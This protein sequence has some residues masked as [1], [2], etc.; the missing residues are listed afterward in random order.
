MKIYESPTLNIIDFHSENMIAASHDNVDI[1]NKNPG[2]PATQRKTDGWNSI[3][4][5]Q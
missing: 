2:T 1:D 3:D 4:W 5:E